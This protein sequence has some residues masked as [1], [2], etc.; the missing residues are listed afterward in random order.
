[1]YNVEEIDI[2]IIYIY[3]YIYMALRDG[4]LATYIVDHSSADAVK[5]CH[6]MLVNFA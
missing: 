4:F 1:M 6:A 2:I 5:A 3:I